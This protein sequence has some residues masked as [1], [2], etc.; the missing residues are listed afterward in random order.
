MSSLLSTIS[1]VFSKTLILG[2]FLA[3]V[4]FL[5]AFFVFIA[6]WFPSD[7]ALLA[8]L[9]TLDP[10]WKVVT[11]T[12]SAIMLSVLLY[13]LNIPLIKT[14]EGYPWENTV[15]GKWLKQRRQDEYERDYA[16]IAGMQRLLNTMEAK[17]K[18]NAWIEN[19]ENL[20]ASLGS[21][22]FALPLDHLAELD[23]PKTEAQKKWDLVYQKLVERWNYLQ[24]VT[25]NDFPK[26]PSLVLP[27]R[28]GNVIRSFEHYADTEYGMDSV[29]VWP[30]LIAK[31]DSSYA[32][33]IDD[34][35][36]SFDSML[37][38]SVLSGVFALIAASIGIVYQKPFGSPDLLIN[39]LLQIA[40]SVV[41]SYLFYLGSISR[42][43]SWGV[44]VK[45]AFD[46]YR[47]DLLEQ[48]GYKKNPAT[49]AEER[50]LWDNIS[51]Q[52]IYGDK[53]ENEAQ[54]P[55][56][57]EPKPPGPTFVRSQ[58]GDIALRVARGIEVDDD[59]K[60]T[61]V[62]SVTNVDSRRAKKL[63]ITD[64]VSPRRDYEWN[65]AG[66]AGRVIN[67]EGCNPYEFHVGGLAPKAVVRLRYRTLAR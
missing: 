10:Q 23:P 60:K 12:L 30:R 11:I 55:D 19:V 56:Y 61:V 13:S 24:L 36:T 49:K 48:L 14:Y 64:T 54:A 34:A 8:P 41:L 2:H 45:G 33:S 4:V 44:M 51:L 21:S 28:L 3:V 35:K 59:G 50:E 63:I 29:T 32:E 40:V 17:A 5:V 47:N 16:R 27:T 57:A 25:F 15:I 65:S 9:T 20:V 31:I 46:L 66:A 62:I 38:F 7:F 18:N 58:P 52:M 43:A 26:S 42:A 6:P 39:W 22:A 67:V 53:N 37:N 1:G